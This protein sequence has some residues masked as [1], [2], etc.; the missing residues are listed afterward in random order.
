MHVPLC[1]HAIPTF[2]H[3]S[4][5][6]QYDRSGQ[7][8]IEVPYEEFEIEKKEEESQTSTVIVIEF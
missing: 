5:C 8:Q 4:K 6:Y 7:I 2:H 3:C 1:P